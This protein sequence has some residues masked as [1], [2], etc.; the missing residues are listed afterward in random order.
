M[1]TILAGM[2]IFSTSAQ[3]LQFDFNTVF[4]GTVM[5]GGSTP[6]ATATF[7][8]TSTVTLTITSSMTTAGQFITEMSFNLDPA[9]DPTKLS[10][11]AP[12]SITPGLTAPTITKGV[13]GFQA[14]GDGKFDI[15]FSFQQ[16]SGAG[17]FDGTDSVTYTIT[18]TEAGLTADSFNFLSAPGGGAGSWSAATHIQGIDDLAGGTTS[19]WI[20]PGTGAFPTPEPGTMLL[21]G[22]GLLG[23]GIV[24]RKHS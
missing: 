8:G 2:L 24:A 9:L 11:S 14:D 18:S 6:W 20:G 5:P 10:F 1:V 22:L 15:L 3:A 23:L 16:A 7:S 19:D 17:R 12:V 4:S 21:L 13:N